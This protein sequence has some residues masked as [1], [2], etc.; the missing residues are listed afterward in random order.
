LPVDG[1]GV[2]DQ[3]P[4]D[5]LGIV[6]DKHAAAADNDKFLFL[7]GIEPAHEDVRADARREFDVCHG[8][9]GDAGVEEVAAYGIDIGRFLARQAE[10]Q[11]DVVG[12]KGPKDVFLPTDL[13]QGKAAGINVLEAADFSR[14]DHFFQPDNGGVVVQDVAD[15]EGFLFLCGK[16]H[17]LFAVSLGEGKRLFYED[18]LAGGEDLGSDVVVEGG[19]G[20]NDDA[21]HG[22]IG[23]DVGE[24]AGNGDIRI[25]LRHFFTDGLSAVADGLQDAKLMEVA[26]KVLAPVA[27]ADDG[28]VRRK[29]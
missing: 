12:G 18:V 23:E 26:D 27:R 1:V 19:R 13:S 10:D 8:D 11:G 16:V 6:K 22:A 2:V 17:Q 9:V 20:G 25:G 4:F 7:V 29:E 5:W 24:V 15:E 21:G 3:F 28:D 14:A